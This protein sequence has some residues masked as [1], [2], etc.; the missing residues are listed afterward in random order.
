MITAASVVALELT[1]LVAGFVTAR[2]LTPSDYGLMGVAVVAT[3]LGLQALNFRVADSLVQLPADPGEAYDY[4]FT[5]MVWLVPVYLAITA[6]AAVVT[7][8]LYQRANLVPLCLLLAVLGIQLPAE[9]LR[10]YVQREL[11]W[12]LN[13]VT[14]TAGPMVGLV[15]SLVLAFRGAGYWALAWGLVTSTLISAALLWARAPRLPRLR[16]TVPRAELLRFLSFGVPLWL[17]GILGS[18]AAYGISLE[19]QVALGIGFIGLYR[20][21]ISIGDRIDTAEQL[22]GAVL[23]PVIC[24]ITDPAS[25]KRAFELSGQLVLVWA[26]P[27]GLGLAVF[28]P[29]IV[30]YALGPRW[31]PIVPLLV[32]EG[33][34]E[35][36]NAV[37][38]LWQLFYVAAGKTKPTLVMG[39][40]INVFLLVALGLMAMR[41]GYQ[42]VVV[43]FF[44]AVMIGLIQRMRYMDRLLPGTT[45]FRAALPVLAAGLIAVAGTLAVRQVAGGAGVG[46]F[47]LRV[48][49]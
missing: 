1:R 34:G 16:R 3:G 11:R 38:T 27:A 42:G 14:T 7:A 25:L 22:V 45:L 23:F 47:A 21:T 40:Q 28:A 32:V 49:C 36:L 19:L 10:V 31:T 9:V 30:R 8:V 29:D 17:A 37:G 48:G 2:L 5:L 12:W 26:V 15:V 33:V 44:A 6:G 24:R 18:V 35:T 41:F 46:N 43:T 13:R 4:G 39:A 20:L